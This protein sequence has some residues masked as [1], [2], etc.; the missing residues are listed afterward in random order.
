MSP[1]SFQKKNEARSERWVDA[2]AELAQGRG[3]SRAVA[4]RAVHLSRQL[5]ISPWIAL[6]IAERLITLKEAR[7]LDRVGRCRELQAAILDKHRTLDELRFMMPYAA[8]FLATE[9]LEAYPARK[10]DGRLLVRILEGVLGAEKKIGEEDISFRVRSC[11]LE[12][13]AAAVERIMGIMQRTRCDAGMALD[14][15]AGR[16][17]EVFAADLMRQKRN[18]EIEERRLQEPPSGESFHF[19]PRRTDFEMRRP[20][21]QRPDAPRVNPSPAPARDH[22]PREVKAPIHRDHWPK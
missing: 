16:V 12:E 17:T 18:L 15:D 2:L 1:T 14:V 20:V 11:S 13:Y 6:G 22:W 3:D 4:M 5:N 7:L 8:H 19:P 9:L 21:F 10:W